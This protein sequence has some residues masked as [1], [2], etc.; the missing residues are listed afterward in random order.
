MAG[1][2]QYLSALAHLGL[3]PS[4]L[5][6]YHSYYKGS[7][8]LTQTKQRDQNIVG[9]GL[10][11][12]GPHIPAC[13]LSFI[14]SFIARFPIQR[15]GAL[16]QTLCGSPPACLAHVDSVWRPRDSEAGEAV[17]QL[18]VPADILIDLGYAGASGS[19]SERVEIF[20]PLGLPKCHW[21]TNSQRCWM[22]NSSTVL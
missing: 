8:T 10:L 22:G 18:A 3:E 1:C 9:E 14:Y 21:R 16:Q 15:L 4:V 2:T 13:T 5:A 11:W 6:S 17:H 12:R 7:R 19:A 20:S